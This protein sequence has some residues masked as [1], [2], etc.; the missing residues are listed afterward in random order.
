MPNRLEQ[1]RP[2]FLLESPWHSRAGQVRPA[3]WV[4]AVRTLLCI[5]A[6]RPGLLSWPLSLR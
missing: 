3:D 4:K 1:A 6:A 5:I 2:V